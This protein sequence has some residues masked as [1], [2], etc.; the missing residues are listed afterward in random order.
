MR[1][2]GQTSC[3]S[4]RSRIRAWPPGKTMRGKSGTW[5]WDHRATRRRRPRYCAEAV[6]TP[7]TT[8]L[9]VARKRPFVKEL[10][11]QCTEPPRRTHM[12]NKVCTIISVFGPAGAR[13]ANQGIPGS[14]LSHRII[15]PILLLDPRLFVMRYCAAKSCRSCNKPRSCDSTLVA[16]SALS[17]KPRGSPRCRP[18]QH[19][20]TSR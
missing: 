4:I 15:L 2:Y 3:A 5:T 14:F 12:I 13:L 17:F 11:G 20:L 18:S 6:T 16:F 1:C 19:A 8:S 7:L 10:R 9:R